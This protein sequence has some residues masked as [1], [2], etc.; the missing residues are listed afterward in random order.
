MGVLRTGG[1]LRDA[2]KKACRWM[3][4]ARM[5][6]RWTRVCLPGDEYRWRV[7]RLT[8]CQWTGARRM[9]WDDARLILL[10]SRRLD[11]CAR[12][13]LPDGD[14][15]RLLRRGRMDADGN[16]EVCLHPQRDGSWGPCPHSPCGGG[17]SFC[18]LPTAW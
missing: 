10:L 11:A 6:C 1:Q 5:A 13:F 15:L 7:F 17:S 4:A 3:G 16:L 8:V 14:G 2:A 18:L 12:M 9:S